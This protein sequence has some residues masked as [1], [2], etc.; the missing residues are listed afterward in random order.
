DRSCR[1][2]RSL[3]CISLT[4]ARLDRYPRGL[5]GHVADPIISIQAESRTSRSGLKLVRF[6]PHSPLPIAAL[7]SMSLPPKAPFPQS[8]RVLCLPRRSP[9]L[10]VVF[11]RRRLG[12]GGSR[13][14]HAPFLLLPPALSKVWRAWEA[15][16]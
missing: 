16:L 15:R 6:P 5:T 8:R 2:P 3:Q 11:K 9:W 14:P 1:S 7:P 12:K 10:A 13:V 4:P